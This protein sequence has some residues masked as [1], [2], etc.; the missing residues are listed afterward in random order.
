MAKKHLT[1]RQLY[2]AYSTVK[3]ENSNLKL[4][5]SRLTGENAG[6]LNRVNGQAIDIKNKQSAIQKAKT[7]NGELLSSI[8]PINKKAKRTQDEND[9]LKANL[10]FGCFI[11]GIVGLLVGSAI[12]GL[13]L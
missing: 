3:A 13:V 12:T 5:N 2:T 10:K 1:Y 7:R 9:K 6:L 4:N 8:E 11:A